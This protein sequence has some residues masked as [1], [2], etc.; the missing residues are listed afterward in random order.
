MTSGRFLSVVGAFALFVG[1][2]AGQDGGQSTGAAGATGT[3][4]ATSSGG[5]SGTGTAGT[6]GAAAFATFFASLM[7]RMAAPASAPPRLPANA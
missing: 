4:G 6:V 7:R 5:S 2:C 3:G 1:A